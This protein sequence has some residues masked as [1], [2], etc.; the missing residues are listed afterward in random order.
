MRPFLEATPTGPDDFS[1]NRTRR[2]GSL[3]ARSPACRELVM[4]PL[5]LGTVGTFLGHATNFQLHL[6]QAIAIGPGE[7]AQPIHRDQWAFDFFPFP[8][9]YEVQC[10]FIWALTDF[11]EE[12]GATRVVPGSN[13]GEDRMSFGPD[14]TEPAE[15]SRGSVL[16][17]SG[18][19]YHGGGANRSDAD[20]HR[21]E[22]HLQ[23]GLVA[24]GGEPV[25]LRA[26]GGGR[27]LADRPLAGHGLRPGRLRVGLHRRLCAIRSKRYGRG[28]VRPVSQSRLTGR[29]GS[30][31]RGLVAT[32]VG[33]MPVE[34]RQASVVRLRRPLRGVQPHRQ[35]GRGLSAKGTGGPGRVRRVLDRPFRRASTWP[36][37]AAS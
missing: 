33:G 32:T 10:N 12:N 4:H 3:I 36:S 26:A 11:T 5:V 8:P 34:I 9:G 18:S 25:P 7:S 13:L 16:C 30:I 29:E 1:G 14:D 22:H 23:R 15:M 2:T 28:S 20:A 24:P 19:V 17:Y 6:T 27:H 31:V 37:S 35:R 21:V